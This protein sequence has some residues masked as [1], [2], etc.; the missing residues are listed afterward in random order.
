MWVKTRDSDDTLVGVDP[1]PMYLPA[2]HSQREVDSTGYGGDGPFIYDHAAKTLVDDVV[3]QLMVHKEQQIEGLRDEFIVGLRTVQ[4]VA[5]LTAWI[6][7]KASG[8]A[9]VNAAANKAAAATAAANWT[10]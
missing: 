6:G 5:E 10:K 4:T 3:A 1:E 2:G 9:A 7:K 8:E